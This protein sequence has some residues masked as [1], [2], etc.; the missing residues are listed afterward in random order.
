[1]FGEYNG[2]NYTFMHG[3]RVTSPLQNHKN[4][5]FLGNTDLN[6]MKV[7]EAAKPAFTVGPSLA[8]TESPFFRWWA[9]DSPLIV[10]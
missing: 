9:N 10:V 5:G 7:Y 3:S 2:S 8:A 4:I 1:M 6:P